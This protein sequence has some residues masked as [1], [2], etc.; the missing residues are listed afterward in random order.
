MHLKRLTIPHSTKL[1]HSYWELNHRHTCPS[2]DLIINFFHKPDNI[3]T[4]SKSTLHQI[5]FGIVKFQLSIS[6]IRPSIVA[7]NTNHIFAICHDISVTD[8]F[9][10]GTFFSPEVQCQLY[11]TYCFSKC[12]QNQ[13]RGVWDKVKVWESEN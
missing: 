10:Y 1:T 12:K 11:M 3:K 7:F 6:I 2:V 13:V 9:I 8:Q 5:S 4:L